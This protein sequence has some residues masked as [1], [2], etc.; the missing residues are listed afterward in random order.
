M[1]EDSNYGSYEVKHYQ[2]T[3]EGTLWIQSHKELLNLKIQANVDPN[4]IPF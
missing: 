4:D 3:P 2:A 1:E